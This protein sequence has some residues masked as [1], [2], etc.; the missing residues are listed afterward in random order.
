MFTK[1]Y[2]QTGKDVSAISFGGMRFELEADI[3]TN[4][5]L[6]VY[7]H[8]K[9]I[10]YFDSAPGYDG[11]DSEKTLGAAF[12]QMDRDS[13][14]VSTKSNKSH[15]GEL[16]ADLETSMQRM[17]VD[18]VDF[19]H[20]WWVVTLEAWR[21]RVD[22]GAVAEAIRLKEEG[23]IKHLV[24]SSHL[25]GD[26][27]GVVM[28]EA[29]FE[30]VLLG[31]CAINFPFRESAVK[32]AG[33]KDLGVVTMN[34]LGGGVIPQNAERL[35][36]LRA[37]DDPSVVAAALRFNVS[38]PAIT[39]A[40]VGFTTKQ[41]VDEACAAMENFTPYDPEHVER[42]RLHLKEKFG[43]LCTGCG[44][45]MP[46]PN[47]VEMPKLMD[48]YNQLLL[49]DDPTILADRL[50]WHWTLDPEN[51]RQ[52]TNCGLCEQRCTQHL[53]IVERMN[54]LYDLVQKHPPKFG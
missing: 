45:C 15:G 27:L 50:K 1:P 20:I 44:Y 10:N 39:S 18:C 42:V 32:L 28:Q 34:P 23:L 5:E 8:S 47:D 26:D 30:G 9:G 51:I 49:R 40:L 21:G 33:E 16:R 12:K 6:V 37:K 31:Y 17:G 14:Y 46:C 48:T 36:W 2:G 22:G 53:P 52:C 41:H 25:P 29:P 35:D 7:A 54:E 24:L 38:N 13:F 11:G 19:F 4:A 3:K 43:G